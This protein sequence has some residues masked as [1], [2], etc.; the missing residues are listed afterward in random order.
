MLSL[1]KI[2]SRKKSQQTTKLNATTE[3]YVQ[4][5][6]RQS[7]NFKTV[8][9]V[10]LLQNENALGDLYGNAAD[11]FL[12]KNFLSSSEVDTI[13]S[14]FDKV[15]NDN[16]AYTSVGFTYPTV[17]AEF[18]GRV[19]NIEPEKRDQMITDYFDKNSGFNANF[20][21]E[22]GVD[23]KSKLEDMFEKIAGGKT[24]QVAEGMNGRGHYPFS[25]FRYL[26]PDK[27]L[28]SV[29]CGNYFG[30]TFEK[31]Y[32]DLTK[33]VAVTNQMSFFIMLQEPDAGGEL[34]LFNFRW[35]EGQTKTSPSEDNE[36]IQPDGSKMY[37]E[38]N[39]EIIKDKI[40]PKK[41]DMIL[42]QGG[43]IWH[44]VET[45]RGNTPR[46]TFGGF[47]SLSLDKTKF[48]YWS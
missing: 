44:R 5:F 7:Y 17:F 19:K 13:M 46:I 34:S 8:K 21:N 2:F 11:G 40:V 30:K 27:G 38:N 42:F 14:H 12:I 1:K 6:T 4:Q 35:K 15:T 39:K 28:M 9:L 48:Y 33:R 36:I 23:I 43:N 3:K 10:E 20:A 24:I 22:F 47:M 18:S 32:E 29:H 41:G 25:T 37:V 31:F 16:P 45:V 26:I